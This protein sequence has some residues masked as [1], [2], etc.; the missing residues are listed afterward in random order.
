[1]QGESLAACRLRDLGAV[2]KLD[3]RLLAHF[4]VCCWV[5]RPGITCEMA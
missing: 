4:R 2:S 3:G 5:S 1:M